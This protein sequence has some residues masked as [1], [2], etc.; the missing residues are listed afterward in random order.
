MH[1]LF[2]SLQHALWFRFVVS[3]WEEWLFNF[4]DEKLLRN[5]VANTAVAVWQFMRGWE[6]SIPKQVLVHWWNSAHQEKGNHF[7]TPKST[8]HVLK[9]ERMCSQNFSAHWHELVPPLILKPP[10]SHPTRTQHLH[11]TFFPDHCAWSTMQQPESK[12]GSLWCERNDLIHCSLLT[13]SESMIC[14]PT[15]S[16][17]CS[18]HISLTWVHKNTACA[19]CCDVIAC[20]SSKNFVFWCSLMAHGFKGGWKSDKFKLTFDVMQMWLPC[21]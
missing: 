15:F 4:H 8:M 3:Y 13:E 21:D 6:Q 2:C 14:F 17:C 12:F 1:T 10:N 19:A 16:V 20:C 7:P 11:P 9:K 18:A 5:N